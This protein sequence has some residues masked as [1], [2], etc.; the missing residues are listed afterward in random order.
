M[1]ESRAQILGHPI[2]PM[3][4]MFPIALFPLALVFDVVWLVT[5]DIFWLSGAFWILL[6]GVVGTLAAIVPGIVDY[7]AVVPKTGP[8]RRTA[9]KHLVTGLIIAAVSILALALRYAAGAYTFGAES[10]EVVTSWAYGGVALNLVNNLLIVLQGWWGGTLVY[11]HH[12]G[13]S[14]RG[15]P[16][17][18][19]RD[20][21][22]ASRRR[23]PGGGSP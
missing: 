11:D 16:Q 4:V 15:G 23:E 12:I 2:H 1:V 20:V 5:G 14:P 17:V 19:P 21:R 22:E 10:K 13:P 18:E 3:L 6:A 7:V 8:A 9:N